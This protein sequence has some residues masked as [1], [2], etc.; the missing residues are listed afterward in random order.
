MILRHP[1]TGVVLKTTD[2]VLAQGATTQVA[3]VDIE[4]SVLAGNPSRPASYSVEIESGFPGYFQNILWTPGSTTLTNLSACHQ[5]NEVLRNELFGVV[6]S[7]YDEF[8][9][10]YVAISNPS[11]APLNNVS[12][13]F[14]NSKGAMIGTRPYAV[15]TLAPRQSKMLP[16][17]TLE[18][19]AGLVATL[20]ESQYRLTAFQDGTVPFKGLLQHQSLNRK[21]GV[22]TDLTVACK[23]PGPGP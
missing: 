20:A 7:S 14:Y 3:M 18:A 21:S 17:A 16:V 13:T 1:D 22:F 4:G 5:D 6:S 9:A 12:L 2:I 11:S 19:G 8:Y 23:L 10:S 15:G